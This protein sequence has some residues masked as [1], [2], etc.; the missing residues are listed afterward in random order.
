MADIAAVLVWQG[1]HREERIK[2]PNDV[3]NIVHN[4]LPDDFK[5]L[6]RLSR[7]TFET[8]LSNLADIPELARRRTTAGRPE[9][10]LEKDPL[11]T[12]WYLG[13]QETVKSISDRFN[14][15]VFT[16]IAHNRRILDVC[17]NHL[18]KIFIRWPNDFEKVQ[19]RE[20]FESVKGFPGPI[21]TI[22]GTHIQMTPPAENEAD[23][24]NR[25]NFHSIILQAVRK[26]DRAFTDIYCGWPGRVNDARV[27]RNSHLCENLHV[28]V[29]QNHIIGDCAY[30]LSR[31]LMKPYR[32][33][34]HLSNAEKLF[35]KSLCSSRTV[36]EHAF[37]MMKGRF[38]R[39]Q[40]INMHSIEYI[41]K[42]VI[43]ACILHNICILND[44][45]LD[46][47]FE[48][49]VE[50]DNVGLNVPS[51]D[52]EGTLKRLISLVRS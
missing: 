5:R 42:A 39:L 30:P 14:V 38:R 36:I 23:Y 8:L 32:D 41:V 13:S 15:Q 24:A 34:G 43:T 12:L 21:G 48:A 44:D 22:D 7:G 27:F 49:E 28:M 33:N 11:M 18:C 26:H 16:F 35:N 17:C 3:P 51:G 10:S 46:D 52:A 4:Y 29:G 1:L 20:A 45:E 47:H 37:G 9:V 40:N 19:V 25:K 2:I 50:D 31:F 6:F